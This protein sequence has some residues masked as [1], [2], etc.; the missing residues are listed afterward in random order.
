MDSHGFCLVDV[1]FCITGEAG[2]ADT[3]SHTGKF[4]GC[5][6]TSHNGGM[7]PRGSTRGASALVTLVCL[8]WQRRS[9]MKKEGEVW[10]VAWSQLPGEQGPTRHSTRESGDTIHPIFSSS[11]TPTFC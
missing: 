7:E 2:A 1:F 9:V 11:V 6:P 10:G 4:L 5:P 3:H 8:K